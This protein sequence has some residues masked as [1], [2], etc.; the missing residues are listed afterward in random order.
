MVAVAT[1][2]SHMISW[3]CIAAML[4]VVLQPLSSQPVGELFN[5]PC[6]QDP[7]LICM[8]RIELRVSLGCAESAIVG[9]PYRLERQERRRQ[10]A[11]ACGTCRPRCRQPQAWCTVPRPLRKTTGQ[12]PHQPRL[13]PKGTGTHHVR[14]ASQRPDPVLA[15]CLIRLRVFC[16]DKVRSQHSGH[17]GRSGGAGRCGHPGPPARQVSQHSRRSAAGQTR[18]RRD[19]LLVGS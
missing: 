14:A 2:I 1:Y 19:E 7:V 17:G 13:A 6:G 4:A 15:T 18:H 5:E 11:A 12:L 16:L 8:I 10:H 9:M 3:R